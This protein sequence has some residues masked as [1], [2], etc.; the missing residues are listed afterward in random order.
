M[1]AY[2]RP[3]AKRIRS[4][5]WHCSS[6]GGGL[7]AWDLCYLKPQTQL[8]PS[9]SELQ[10]FHL[11][12]HRGSAAVIM[13]AII[14]PWGARGIVIQL[15]TYPRPLLRVEDRHQLLCQNSSV[16]AQVF[17]LFGALVLSEQSLWK[18]FVFIKCPL[19]PVLSWTPSPLPMPRREKPLYVCTSHVQILRGNARSGLDTFLS[20]KRV[21]CASCIGT[22]LKACWLFGFANLSLQRT[23]LFPFLRADVI[24]STTRET[25][26]KTKGNKI[27]VQFRLPDRKV[28][29][30]Q[31][32]KFPE[33]SALATLEESATP[34][35]EWSLAVKTHVR[36][37]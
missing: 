33:I 26:D 15:C 2:L 25:Q 31:Q 1:L 20:F 11:A 18:R 4:G 17:I 7:L 16:W 21:I 34:G 22:A 29:N 12:G 9:C 28:W 35:L 30:S 8:P 23:L 36:Q 32:F 3:D 19:T 37:K 13:S 10:I 5:A 14:V 24:P 27:P 6:S